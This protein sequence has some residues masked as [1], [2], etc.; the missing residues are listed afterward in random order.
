MAPLLT[1]LATGHVS[2]QT[3]ARRLLAHIGM[4]VSE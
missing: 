3:A 2:P 1:E 4:E